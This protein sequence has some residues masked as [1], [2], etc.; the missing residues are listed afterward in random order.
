N[1]APEAAHAFLPEVPPDRLE[2]LTLQANGFG[3]G[4]L[5]RAADLLNAG[6]TE[7]SG[8]T[9]PRLQLELI[10]ARIL[11]PGSGRSR[12]AVLSRVER[13]ERRIGM[14]AT[15][16]AANL[17]P[18]QAP[19][20][21]QAS[22]QAQAPGPG[23]AQA[24]GADSPGSGAQEASAPAAAGRGSGAAPDTNQSSAGNDDFDDIAAMA[25]AAESM[26]NEPAQ[27]TRSTGPEESAPTTQEPEAAPAAEQSTS[28]PASAPG[29][30][31][32]QS[33]APHPNEPQRSAPE[34]S[35]PETAAAE[36]NGRERPADAPAP[37]TSAPDTG[38]GQ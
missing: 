14:S 6:L 10:C 5:S 20:P 18:A 22:G 21:G 30:G 23:Q 25:V 36:R 13:M 31:D 26:L 11:L 1:A 37:E 4:E 15:G 8:A 27:P 3:Q 32:Q 29:H 2:R 12:D 38:R 24:P 19:G 17:P 28:G 16:A 9:S 7:M 35:G 34:Q 33:T